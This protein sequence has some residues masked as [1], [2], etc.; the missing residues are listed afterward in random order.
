MSIICN[1]FDFSSDPLLLKLKYNE[2]QMH[3]YGLISCNLNRM[4][5]MGQKCA[6]DAPKRTKK[7][8][9]L[10][11]LTS[12]FVLFPCNLIVLFNR[13]LAVPLLNY[14]FYL[15]FNLPIFIRNF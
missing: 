5:L 4:S 3:S 14:R 9:F 13:T 10:F 7:S 15:P 6:N 2:S 11:Y 1:N 12:I 8:L